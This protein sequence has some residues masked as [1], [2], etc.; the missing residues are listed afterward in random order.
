MLSVMLAT[1]LFLNAA[2]KCA[3]RED[4]RGAW[5]Q[6]FQAFNV[7]LQYYHVLMI[8]DSEPAFPNSRVKELLRL[9]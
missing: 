1:F 8:Q 6:S 9:Q 3:G 5:G 7:V 2:V 4:N